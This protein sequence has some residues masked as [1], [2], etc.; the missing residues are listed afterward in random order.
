VQGELK[1]IEP[2]E[3]L[4]HEDVDI[5]RVQDVAREIRAARFFYP[6]L[7]V[8]RSTRVILDGHHRWRASAELGLRVLPCWCVDYLQDPLIRVMS[9]RPQI[10]VSKE[11]VIKTALAGTTYPRK[12][13]RHMYDLPEWVEPVPLAR[14]GA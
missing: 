11:A 4:P 5:A 14:L 3:L 7:L 1:L 6:P 12:T 10:D 2:G 9:R 13:T 8:D